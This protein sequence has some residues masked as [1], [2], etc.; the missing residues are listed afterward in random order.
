MSLTIFRR[1][2]PACRKSTTRGLSPR[3]ARFFRACT[4][5]CWITGTT[6][7]EKYPRQSLGTTDWA[8]AEARVRAIQAQAVDAAVHGPTISACI[9]RH[10]ATHTDVVGPRAYEHHRLV[11]ARFEAFAHGRNVYHM[12]E[13]SVDLVEDFVAATCAK[14]ASGTRALAVSKLKVFLREAHRRGWITDALALKVRSV[15]AVFEQAQPY[16]DDEV[17][18]IL[19]EAERLHA[20]KKYGYASQPTTFRLLLE[21]MLETG[22]RVSDAIRFAPRRCTKS[23]QLW[24]YTFEPCKQRRKTTKPRQHEVFLSD[25]LHAA[26]DGTP[27]LSKSH[28]FAYRDFGADAVQEAA[29]YKTM[30]AIG[31]RCGVADC[32]PHRLRDTFAVRMLLKGVSLENV[33]HLLGHSSIAVTQA[34]YAPWCS[35]RKLRLEGLVAETFMQPVG[36]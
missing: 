11:L 19:D 35:S 21:L 30:R 24:V 4:C 31:E 28:P 3:E 29:V 16:A 36:D 26:I 5:P 9:R 22:V 23:K 7:T 15:R 6:D 33:S 27:W 12:S 18:R 13:L 2:T 8:V 34:H 14:L 20:V 10:L 17:R 32:R 25:R 1:H